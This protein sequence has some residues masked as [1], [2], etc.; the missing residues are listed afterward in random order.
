MQSTVLA[1]TREMLPRGEGRTRRLRPL[2]LV[3]PPEVRLELQH[4]L[5]RFLTY[6]RRSLVSAGFHEVSSPILETQFWNLNALFMYKYHPVRSSR[7]LLAI[8]GISLRE[9]PPKRGHNTR[10]LQEWFS[11]EYEGEGTSGSRGWGTADGF[12]ND[13]VV[14]RSHSTPE[15]VKHL[16]LTIPFHVRIFGFSRCCRARPEKPEFMQ[17]DVLVA[18]D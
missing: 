3:A 7:H 17:M 13:Q 4:P 18:D 6:L 2:S 5:P 9:E 11:K 14:I 15:T 10:V 8:D 12:D 1:V 16:A